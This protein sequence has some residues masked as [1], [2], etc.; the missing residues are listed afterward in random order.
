MAI[1]SKQI[2]RRYMSTKFK[3]SKLSATKKARKIPIAKK[4]T[5][6]TRKNLSIKKDE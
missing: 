1:P 5:I 3:K 6:K 4:K 2:T